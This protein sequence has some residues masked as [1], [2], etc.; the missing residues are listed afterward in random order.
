MTDLVDITRTVNGKPYRI[1]VEPRRSLADALRENCGQTGTR[2]GCEH[3]VCGTCT[4]LYDGAPMRPC[5]MCA[6][7]AEGAELRTVEGLAL[8]D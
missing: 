8:V 6:V 7:R 3:R 5:L 2:L 1:A 4:A